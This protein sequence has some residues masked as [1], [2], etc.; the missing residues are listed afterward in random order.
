MKTDVVK[1]HWGT[2]ASKMSNSRLSKQRQIVSC[3]IFLLQRKP[4][5]GPTKPSTG[6][7]AARGLDIAG[8]IRQFA[9]FVTS[10]DPLEAFCSANTS[11]AVSLLMSK[12]LVRE[13][14]EANWE[15]LSEN[16]CTSQFVYRIYTR[17][18]KR[19]PT[20]HWENAGSLC[21]LLKIYRC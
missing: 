3:R 8:L 18:A 11:F 2:P 5:L 4:K 15:S 6:P 17:G 20:P 9:Q 1:W 14:M 13:G 7:D 16:C 19:D 10:F 12:Q 21:S